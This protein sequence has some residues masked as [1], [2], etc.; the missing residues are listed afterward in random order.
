MAEARLTAS[1]GGNRAAATRL[2]N[3]INDIIADATTTRLQKIHELQNKIENLEA[4]MATIEVLDEAILEELEPEDVAAEM[5]AADIHKQ[6]L[7]DNK[8][9]FTFQLRTLQDAEDAANATL[10]LATAPI[11]PATIATPGPSASV[12]PKL[13]LP[14]FKWDILDWSSFWDVFESGVDSKSYGGYTKFNFL[15]SKLEGE[16]KAALLGL[17]SSNGNYVK[18]KDILHDRYNQPKEVVTAHY[19][20]LINLP[21]ANALDSNPLVPVYTRLPINSNLIFEVSKPL[22][23]LLLS[24]AISSFVYSLKNL[25]STYVEILHATKAPW[26]G[27]STNCGQPSS[28]RSK[29]WEIF[30]SNHF[31]VLR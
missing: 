1:R 6:T 8:D 2:V 12:L 25:P 11:G 19:K 3:K 7:R 17:T 18:T 31:L 27:L 28:A 15:I 14:I 4:K 13:D 9:G 21:A 23:Q 10:A 29:S 26:I 30:A 20:A 22:V 24:K 5:N 16:A